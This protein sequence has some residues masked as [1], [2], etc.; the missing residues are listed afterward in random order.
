MIRHLTQGHITLGGLLGWKRRRLRILRRYGPRAASGVPI[1]FG[2]AIPKCGSTLLFNILRTL[3]LIG[4]F[5]DT[6]LAGIKPFTDSQPTSIE[7][8]KGQLSMLE[9]GDV[10]FGYLFANSDLIDLLTGPRQAT[11]M[12]YRDPRDHIVSEIFYALEIYPGHAMHGYMKSLPNMQARIH[13]LIVGIDESPFERASVKVQFERFVPWI[14]HP[15]VHAMRFEDLIS[16]R[17]HQLSKMLDYLE[18]RGYEPAL[19]RQELVEQMITGMAPRKSSTFRKGKSGTWKEHFSPDNI[20]TFKQE[21]GDLLVELGYEDD[22]N[23]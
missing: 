14:V 7:W 21:A 18:A 11:F 16:D 19:P 10:R 15:G 20:S 23:W 17:E 9:P 22:L 5:V 4:P 3:E 2:N 1:V 6:G 12:I 13:A 8:I